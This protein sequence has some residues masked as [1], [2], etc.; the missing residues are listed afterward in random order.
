MAMKDLLT[1][2]IK[3]QK[4]LNEKLTDLERRFLRNNITISGVPKEKEGNLM[5]SYAEQLLKTELRLADT[6]LHIQRVYR[7]LACKLERN[8]LPRF[9]VVNFLE[10]ST[11]EMV[12][13][14]SMGKEDN[15]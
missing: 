5:S 1:K 12:L 11:K 15:D 8:A 4:A 14:K 2:S 7:A 3:Q 9:I 13:E 6:N 10:F